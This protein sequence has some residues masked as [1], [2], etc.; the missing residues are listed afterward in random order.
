[1]YVEYNDFVIFV[2]HGCFALILLP[3]IFVAAFSDKLN[4]F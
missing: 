1:M 4:K 2:L 3:V